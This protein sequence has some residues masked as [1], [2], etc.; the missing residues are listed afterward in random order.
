MVI[1]AG[2]AFSPS[3]AAGSRAG[4][5]PRIS[6]FCGLPR[7]RGKSG[8]FRVAAETIRGA[9]GTVAVRTALHDE[10]AEDKMITTGSYLF[11]EC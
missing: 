5:W 9:G 6:I 1:V 8:P 3:R 2:L 11:E 10:G 7:I 4:V